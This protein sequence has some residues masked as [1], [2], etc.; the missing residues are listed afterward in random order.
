[1]TDVA[2]RLAT[3]ES[4]FYRTEQRRNIG[5]ADRPPG[6]DT[7]NPRL[8][9]FYPPPHGAQASTC[10]R[11]RPRPTLS[12]CRTRKNVLQYAGLQLPSHS[13]SLHYSRTPQ[14]SV[15]DNLNKPFFSQFSSYFSY[16]FCTT[17]NHRIYSCHCALKTALALQ[18]KYRTKR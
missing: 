10:K 13:K 4:D 9:G 14:L 11:Y 8:S 1:M 12:A 16:A 6:A 7:P 17:P 18:P 2:P 3:P 5:R 15:P